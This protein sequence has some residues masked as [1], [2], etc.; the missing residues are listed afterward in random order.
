VST[1][2]T[3]LIVGGRDQGV[4]ELNQEAYERLRCA[5]EIKIVTGATHLFEEPG[6]WTRLR[7]SLR[8]GSCNMCHAQVL[9]RLHNG[10]CRPAASRNRLLLTHQMPQRALARER[11]PA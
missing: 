7:V 10:P 2:P 3:L 5:K 11:P 6:P 4:I 8:N 9:R 1:A